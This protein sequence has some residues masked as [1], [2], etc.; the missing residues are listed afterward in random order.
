MEIAKARLAALAGII[1]E[2]VKPAEKITGISINHVT[3]LNRN[4]GSEGAGVSPVDLT[5]NAILDMAVSCPTM[6]RIGDAI[7]MNLDALEIEKKK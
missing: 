3:G 6:K 4:E 2:L 5:V 7:G 1:G